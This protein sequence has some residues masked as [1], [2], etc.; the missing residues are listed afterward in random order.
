MK[1][2]RSTAPPDLYVVLDVLPSATALEIRTAY[3]RAALV[4]H[5]DEG[6][7]ALGFQH[8]VQAFEA[9]SDAAS[10]S[11][12][13]K[14]RLRHQKAQ[15]SST[16]APAQNCSDIGRNRRRRP[17]PGDQSST[18][19]SMPSAPTHN[20]DNKVAE[21]ELQ[22]RL[23]LRMAS[24]LERL[25]RAVQQMS[26]ERRR[27]CINQL[28]QP[29]KSRLVT[30]MEK[31][32]RSSSSCSKPSDQC[33]MPYADDSEDSEV[34]STSG[35]SSSE[36][37]S[38][39]F[40]GFRSARKRLCLPNEEASL[41]L[42]VGSRGSTERNECRNGH[43]HASAKTTTRVATGIY[44]RHRGQ[45]RTY[46]ARVTM[47][48]IKLYTL[49]VPQLD[50]AIEH[51]ILLVQIRERAR[52]EGLSH[53]ITSVC[54]SVLSQSGTSVDEIGLRAFLNMTFG[55]KLYLSSPVLPLQEVAI[56]KSRFVEAKDASWK[57]FLAVAKDLLQHPGFARRTLRSEEEVEKH[58]AAHDEQMTT[59]WEKRSCPA[60]HAAIA[61]RH[62]ED[63]LQ[64]MKAA[65]EVHEQQLSEERKRWF[66]RKPFC[67]MTM[68]DLR[69]A[70]PSE[71][72]ANQ[73]PSGRK[74]MS[75]CPRDSVG[76]SP[77][78]IVD[79]ALRA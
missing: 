39:P 24:A 66:R 76:S 35:G 8:L 18:Q 16:S 12:Y 73:P 69:K 37:P 41:R 21:G 53:R 48:D 56:W 7:S 44:A 79:F 10:R 71:L 25:R 40:G 27:G 49:F 68:E 29:V 70:L 60:K 57:D 63:T 31:A 17:A 28:S 51:H 1:R 47:S 42:D 54:E 9:L 75:C 46:S 5:P 38:S 22:R 36:D 13:D 32:E 55:G 43:G 15:C 50:K 19:S 74:D 72:R 11:K 77:T 3:R 59:Y 52:E 4:C 62:V 67:D 61:A 2:L 14:Q 20:R 30:Y 33:I 6:G 65:E 23:E 58:L 45:Y 34:E 26:T 78:C 64:T